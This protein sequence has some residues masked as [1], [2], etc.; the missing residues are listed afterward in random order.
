MSK[1]Q[2]AT[3]QLACDIGG[4]THDP[5]GYVLYNFPWGVKG[6]ALANKTIRKWQRRVLDRIG[7]RLRAGAVDAGEVIREAIAS[8][9]GIGKSA[10]VSMIVKWAFDTMPDTRGV[11]TAN[12]DLQLRTKT[13]A[14]LSKWHEMSLTKAWG[15]LT[16]TALISSLPGHDKTWRIDA[17]P[18]SESNTE[19]FAGLHNEGRRVLLIFDE[20]S[21]IID[22]VW[23]VALGALTDLGTEI[24]WCAFGNPTRNVGAFRECFRPNSGW[25]TESIDTRTVEGTNLVELQKMVDR[26]GE[27]SDVSRVRVR[28]LFP[29]AGS[30]QFIPS[31]ITEASLERRLEPGSWEFAPV[32][33]T[34]DPAWEGDDE[35]VIAKRQGLKFEVLERLAKN[36]N[37]MWVGQRIAQLEDQHRADAVFVDYGY[38]TGIVSFGRSMRRNWMLVNFASKAGKPGFLNKRA[39]IWSDMKDWMEQGG[40]L[41]YLDLETRQQLRAELDAVETKPNLA[42]KVQ[43]ES[44]AELKKRSGFSPNIADALAISFAYTV[45]KRPRDSLGNP[46]VPGNAGSR[47]AQKPGE[48]YNPLG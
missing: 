35:L 9:H 3:E 27:D 46:I 20:A 11:V 45:A 28:G 43:L 14:E 32:I 5:L 17:A 29:S 15:N 22:K 2:S 8:G 1:N 19:A 36:D 21:G 12:T 4:F 23:E 37:D 34:C 33:I 16:A 41:L 6:T 10:L 44:K 24:I 48:P 39:E 42:G 7:R 30:K 25:H 18:W 47:P 38:G 31:A 13:W 26:Y 40:S